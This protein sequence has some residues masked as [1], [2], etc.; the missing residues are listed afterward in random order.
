[1]KLNNVRSWISFS[2]IL[3]YLTLLSVLSGFLGI[4]SSLAAQ[5]RPATT[6]KT[7]TLINLPNGVNQLQ[8]LFSQ[9]VAPPKNFLINNPQR[10]ILDFV[11]VRSNVNDNPELLRQV[12]ASQLISAVQAKTSPERTR[13]MLNLKRSVRYKIRQDGNKLIVSLTNVAKNNQAAKLPARQLTQVDFRKS[14]NNGGQIIFKLTDPNTDVNFVKQGSQLIILLKDIS[15][16]P[17]LQKHFDVNDFGSPVT[18]FDVARAGNN[19]RIIVNTKGN[20]DNFSSLV[21]KQLL[22]DIKPVTNVISSEASKATPYSGKRISLNFQDIKIRAVLQII[23]EFTGLNI[24][25]SDQVKGNITLSLKNVP[26]DQALDIILKSQG[27]AKRQ[28]GN[29]LLVGPSQEI[30]A[31]ERQEL[32]AVQQVA[33]LEPLQSELLQINYGKA[34]D[35]ATILKDKANTLLSSRGT[36]SVDN[37]TNTIWIQDTG[38]KI[39]QVKDLIRRLD[40]PVKQVLIEARIVNINKGY[41]RDLGVKF[42][43]N[44]PGHLGGNLSSASQYANGKSINGVTTLNDRLNM[45][46]PAVNTKNTPATLGL[47]MMR[48][49][50]TGAFLDLELSALETEGEGQV[51]ASPRLITSNQQAA[52][53]E[54]GQ[55]IPYQESTSSGA[56]STSFK[57]AVLSLVVTPQITPDN[58]VILEVKL[59]QDQRDASLTVNGVPALN[60]Q[61]ISTKVLVNNGETLVLGGVYHQDEHKNVSRIPF[62]G[63]IP[64]LGALFRNTQ[65]VNSRSELLI[66]V[67]PKIIEQGSV[68]T[69]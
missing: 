5:N 20:Y 30:A 55:E 54:S 31:R 43:I 10:L 53:I 23:A 66:F 34:S 47:A 40:V 49:G 38:A 32:Q 65:D 24:V 42:G 18:S 9:P 67:T 2:S 11:K 12:R 37:R 4:K 33:D 7:I 22:V 19:I 61:Q 69:L 15:M 13:V 52:T 58:R 6:L 57:K 48:L 51:I 1:M 60:T 39:A 3:I 21:N 63:S 46:L 17:A 41:E 45:N 35:L 44:Q 36:V 26:W 27:L 50:S 64:I 16:L 28:F 62:L 68:E 29:V 14:A 59:N 25:S 8:L 56:T